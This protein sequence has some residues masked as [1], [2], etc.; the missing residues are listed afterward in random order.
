MQIILIEA[1][2]ERALK[3]SF[4][5]NMTISL[6]KSLKRPHTQIVFNVSG[7][8]IFL[9]I[10]EKTDGKPIPLPRVE[11]AL[12]DK[13]A[14]RGYTFVSDINQAD[15]LIEL[16]CEARSGSQ[17]QSLYSAFAD[18]NLSVIQLSDGK[19]LDKS[20][21]TRVKGIDLSF[22]KAQ[23]KALDEIGSRLKSELIPT[24]LEQLNK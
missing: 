6:L 10:S 19:E 4:N 12:K 3:E 8:A 5:I 15:F 18:L 23:Y 9:K 1:D 17:M 14:R 24:M 20:N 16:Q 2:L 13:L 7:P 21:L 11:P 22:E